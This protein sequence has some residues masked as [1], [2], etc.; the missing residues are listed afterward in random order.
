M[1]HEKSVV[2][3]VSAE[4]LPYACISHCFAVLG[5]LYGIWC[6]GNETQQWTILLVHLWTARTN[7]TDSILQDFGILWIDTDSFG[8]DIRLLRMNGEI[9]WE[10]F[11]ALMW[12]CI[13]NRCVLLCAICYTFSWFLLSDS[14]TCQCLLRWRTVHVQPATFPNRL[15]ASEGPV[16]LGSLFCTSEYL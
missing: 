1:I 10:G 5:T 12:C 11:S 6:P 13:F 4:T 16:H 9:D 3:S 8:Y 2:V 15:C 14:Q 7:P